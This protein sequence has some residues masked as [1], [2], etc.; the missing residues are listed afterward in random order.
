[1]DPTAALYYLSCF[2]CNKNHKKKK[3]KIKICCVQIMYVLWSCIIL[4]TE[5]LHKKQ[6]RTLLTAVHE[7]A[8]SRVLTRQFTRC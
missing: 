7:P 6:C 2:G 8:K 5:L 3:I 1:M 4:R